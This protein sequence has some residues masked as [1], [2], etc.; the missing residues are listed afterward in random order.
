MFLALALSVFFTGLDN[1]LV[2]AEQVDDLLVRAVAERSQKRGCGDF[3]R[4]VNV[5]PLNFVGV[6]LVFEPRAS[7]G[8]DGGCITRYAVLVEHFVVVHAR[9]SDKLGYD[10][11]LCTVDDERTRIRHEREIAHKHFLFNHFAGFV[12]GEASLHLE[13]NSIR[14]VAVF[15]LFDGVLGFAVESV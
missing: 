5:H 10:D 14:S 2:P 13:R 12:V 4:S 9:A 1:H 3:S 15:A 7:V 8:D 6:L 11:A